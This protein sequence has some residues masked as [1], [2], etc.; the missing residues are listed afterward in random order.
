MKDHNK[1]KLVSV[2]TTEERAPLTGVLRFITSYQEFMFH[3]KWVKIMLKILL[4]I[5][6]I[7]LTV[8]IVVSISFFLID[9]APGKPNISSSISGSAA[10]AIEEQY[11]L[12][13][14]AISRWV[15]YIKNL[16]VGDFGVSLSIFPSVE[17]NSF[18]WERFLTSS[19][20]GILSLLITLVVGVP[21]GVFFGRKITGLSA[22]AS[23]TLIAVMIS[24]P[25]MVFGLLLLLLGRSMGIPY[26]YSASNL[27]TWIIPSIALALP[28]SIA[29]IKYIRTSMNDEI[30]SQHAKFAKL[31]GASQRRF[32]WRHALKP[33]LFPVATFFPASVLS[34]FIGGLFIEKIFMIP[35][36]GFLMIEAAQTKDTYVILLLTSI[37]TLLTILSF[38]LRDWLYF[39]LDPR[40]RKRGV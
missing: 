4:I 13:D 22:I 21:L 1:I 19:S 23:T 28:S 34:V 11:H 32:I 14:P 12:N 5:I 30:E 25:Q 27:I 9:A 7:I 24:I 6:E 38:R 3:Y 31:K 18:V 26:I 8:L 2:E 36:S 10:K 40:L 29:Y 39:V 33:S 17:I 16:F 37:Y 20:V 15:L 35:G